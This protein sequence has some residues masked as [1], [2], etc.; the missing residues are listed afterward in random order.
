MGFRP[1]IAIAAIGIIA[2]SVSLFFSGTSSTHA[3]GTFGFDPGGSSIKA[4]NSMNGS[5]GVDVTSPA[6]DVATAAGVTFLGNPACDDTPLAP[7][8]AYDLTTKFEFASDC[9]QD[10]FETGSHSDEAAGCGSYNF[11]QLATFAPPDFD[12]SPSPGHPDFNAS[13]DPSLGSVV[14]VSANGATLGLVGN[15]CNSDT[16]P[17]FVWYSATVDIT[18]TVSPAAEGSTDRFANLKTDGNS[19][20]LGDS[21]SLIVTQY[22]DFLNTLFD[23]GLNWPGGS[24]VSGPIQPLARYAGITFVAN[25]QWV[26]LQIV[27]FAP[28]DL[29]SFDDTGAT[30]AGIAGNATHPFAAWEDG[31]GYVSVV[32]LQDPTEVEDFPSSI[33]DFCSPLTNRTLVLGTASDGK[34]VQKTAAASTGTNQTHAFYLYSK[35]LRDADGDGIENLLDTCPWDANLDADPRVHAQDPSNAENPGDMIDS[36]CDPDDDVNEGGVGDFDDDGYKNAQDNC[37]QVING[38]VLS[39][40][41]GGAGNINQKQD[42]QQSLYTSAAP[43]GGPRTDGIGNPCDSEGGGNDAEADGAFLHDLLGH[44][45]CVDGTDDDD[46]GW[47]AGSPTD[48]DDGNDTV[49]AGFDIDGDGFTAGSGVEVTIGTNPVAYCPGVAGSHDTWPPDFNAS[50][51]VDIIDV[52]FFRPV[53]N[54][55]VPPT[56]PRFDLDANGSISII[57]VGAMRPVFNKKCDP[58]VAGG[59]FL[60]ATP[61]P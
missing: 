46:D 17:D 38:T 54:T 27:I 43:D 24:T 44:A 21:N 42:E 36:V 55:S 26:P 6:Q 14:G 4:C 57:D 61:F 53:F 47:C 5:V 40:N 15:A 22:P 29:G 59:T 20:L 35:S 25:V 19:D 41:T 10:N 9:V 39:G 2:L 32:V 13:T 30:P 16:T 34:V 11:S 33:S 8:T 52:G 50:K 37:P 23:P 56:S 7:D 48:N 3:D 45:V 18:D 60:P 31:H 51:K 12:I 49:H 58:A 1:V 28:G